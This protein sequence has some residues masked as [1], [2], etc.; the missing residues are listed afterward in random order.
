MVRI[1]HLVLDYPG[2]RVTSTGLGDTLDYA[3]RVSTLRRTIP[4]PVL[5]SVRRSDS[6]TESKW[7]ALPITLSSMLMQLLPPLQH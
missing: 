6:N 1:V 5:E 7:G 3:L 4:D 2:F